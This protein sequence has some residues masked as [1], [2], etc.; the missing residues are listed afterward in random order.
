MKLIFP[1][2]KGPHSTNSVKC[3]TDSG[4]EIEGVKNIQLDI[5]PDGALEA[6]IRVYVSGGKVE[7]PQP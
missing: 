1:E 4:H 2:G 3:L 6:V 7:K 5:R